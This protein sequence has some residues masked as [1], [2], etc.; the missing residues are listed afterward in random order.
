MLPQFWWDSEPLASKKYH[1]I[2]LTRKPVT[3]EMKSQ[4]HGQWKP[5]E[6][7]CPMRSWRLLC[8]VMLL[9]VCPKL[10]SV[11]LWLES[12]F[13]VDIT[14]SFRLSLYLSAR[15]RGNTTSAVSEHCCESNMKQQQAIIYCGSI[16]QINFVNN[17]NVSLKLWKTFQAF[18]SERINY[19]LMIFF[20]KKNQYRLT[21]CLEFRK[22]FSIPFFLGPV[23]LSSLLQFCS[24]PVS[25]LTHLSSLH[26]D[27]CLSH[28]CCHLRVPA[29]GPTRHP[30]PRLLLPVSLSQTTRSPLSQCGISSCASLSRVIYLS[31]GLQP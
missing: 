30:S 18:K 4:W 2:L 23:V 8:S 9:Q 14:P 27:A 1:Q 11:T 25:D 21:L 16:V 26:F 15:E 6:N 3:N 22:G 24:P 13:A 20:K 19:L 5:L 31:E 12:L 29:A 10:N 28:D 17:L 7:L